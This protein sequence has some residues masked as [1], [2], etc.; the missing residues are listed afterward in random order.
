MRPIHN[1]N[2]DPSDYPPST[3]LEVQVVHLERKDVASEQLY[4]SAVSFGF[5]LTLCSMPGPWQPNSCLLLK[6]LLL[7]S[8][9]E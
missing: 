8:N 4:S 7:H 3:V 6:C 2:R 1:E 9:L 5:R